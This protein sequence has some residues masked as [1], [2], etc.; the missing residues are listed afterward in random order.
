M[1]MTEELK[2][3]LIIS[4]KR[5]DKISVRWSL[6]DVILLQAWT[7]LKKIASPDQKTIGIDS[8]SLPPCIKY[9]PYFINSI[10]FERLECI[11]SQE[12]LKL[13]LRHPTTR[14]AHPKE[15]S[16]LASSITVS[17][18]SMS[19]M[20]AALEM[21]QYIPTPENYDVPPKAHFEKYFRILNDRKDEIDEKIS[22]LWDNMSDEEKK[23]AIQ[24]AL[25]SQQQNDSGEKSEQENS[26]GF[27]K[28]D[29]EKSAV[30]EH[31]NPNGTNNKDWGPNELMDAGIKSIV[32][33]AKGDARSFGKTSADFF[34]SIVAANTIKISVKEVTR[35]FN[36]TAAS[37]STM[38]SRMKIN[39]RYGL[40]FP[41]SIRKYTTK[42]LF[43]VDISGSMSSEEL[44]DGFA[45]INQTCKQAKITYMLFDTKI[46]L[47]EKDMKRAKDT[48]EITGRG[49]T[50]FQEVIDYVNENKFDGVVIFTDGEAPAPTQPNRTKVLWLLTQP[51]YNPPVEWGFRAHLKN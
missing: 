19:S 26:E 49:G 3:A 31:L 33:K 48:F 45:I 9:N 42:I 50:D 35:R 8:R 10:S 27:E 13:L 32:D 28:F 24:N 38:P 36:Q 47:V 39:R 41:G 46:K 18:A 16:S 22:E 15:I 20:F 23:E 40:R 11:L 51:R 29:N 7:S 1:E 43:A 25:D 30:K 44:A 37:M 17:Q 5:L 12:T 4:K 34:E 6:D 14:L 21:E 2:Q